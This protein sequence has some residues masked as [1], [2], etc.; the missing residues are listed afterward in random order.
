[1]IECENCGGDGQC[2][3]CHGQGGVDASPGELQPTVESLTAALE[4]VIRTESVTQAHMD[5]LHTLIEPLKKCGN[6]GGAITPQQARAI[7]RHWDEARK[8]IK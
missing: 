6:T 8:V 3:A 7:L 1:M 4:A 5:A 2:P